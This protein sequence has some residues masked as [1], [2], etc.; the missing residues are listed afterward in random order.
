M[1]VTCQ[2]LE[3]DFV[4]ASCPALL[5]IAPLVPPIPAASGQY[6]RTQLLAPPRRCWQ[7]PT[8]AAG[9]YAFLIGNK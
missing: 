5:V 3:T 9:F 8:P 2:A 6:G 1:I 4:R 7:E